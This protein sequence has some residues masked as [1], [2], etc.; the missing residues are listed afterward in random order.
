MGDKLGRVHVKQGDL[1]TLEIRKYQRFVGKGLHAL[2]KEKR[3]KQEKREPLDL[4]A[5]EAEVED[6][7]RKRVKTD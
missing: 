3:K 4:Q 5:G 7:P 6:A 1:G 2:E